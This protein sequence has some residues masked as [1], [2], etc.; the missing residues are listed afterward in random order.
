MKLR[1]CYTTFTASALLLGAVMLPIGMA[2]RPLV[3]EQNFNFQLSDFTTIAAHRSI[4]ILSYQ[5]FVFG[6]F[7]RLA[8]LVALGTLHGQAAARTVLYPG[9]AIC[10]VALVVNALTSGYYMHMGFWATEE[11]K[12][13]TDA[14]RAS[15]LASLRPGGEWAICLE[16]MAKMFFS[17]GLVVLGSGLMLGKLV[18]KPLGVAALLIG[19]AGMAALFAAPF[20]K[21]IFIPFDIA[22]ALWFAALGGTIFLGVTQPEPTPGTT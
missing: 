2:I 21:T 6:L 9:I 16:R 11:L 5:I 10:A 4:W 1:N 3:V 12:G 20:S 7:M 22:I 8:G 17:F 18:A 13:A 19:I 15:F 14:A